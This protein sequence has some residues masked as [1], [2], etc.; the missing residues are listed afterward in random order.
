MLKAPIINFL[1]T[2]NI[3]FICGSGKDCLIQNKEK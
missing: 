3:T 2:E 1:K